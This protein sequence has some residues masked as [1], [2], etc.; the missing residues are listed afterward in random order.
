[1][2]CSFHLKC[3]VC[4]STYLIKH[5]I[6][7]RSTEF[8]FEC[9]K[10]GI[11]LSGNVN[12][13]NENVKV[14]ATFNNLE[15]FKEEKKVEADI[16]YFIQLSGEFYDNKLRIGSSSDWYMPGSFI[17]N[18]GEKIEEF[19]QLSQYIIEYI[20]FL[21]NRCSRVI[22]LIVNNKQNQKYV[23][24]ELNKMDEY[25]QK[26]IDYKMDEKS[27]L[28][29]YCQEK[30]SILF[31]CVCIPFKLLLEKNSKYFQ[32]DNKRNELIKIFRDNKHEIEKMKLAFE[33]VIQELIKSIV[34]KLGIYTKLL[35][36]L[37]PVIASE[38]LMIN[39]IDSIKK[40]KGLNTVDYREL[41]INYA[42]VYEILG[43]FI[44]VMVAID[45]ILNRGDMSSFYD[46]TYDNLEK[47]SRDS[48][49]NRV[50]YLKKISSNNLR[51]MDMSILNN[52]I[53]NSINHYSYEYDSLNQII[54]FKD[55]TKVLDTYL[56]EFANDNY[57]LM[58]L[59]IEA[60]FVLCSLSSKFLS[61]K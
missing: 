58:Y 47:F 2:N 14:S 21:Y 11:M 55:R 19:G 50:S 3:V 26:F 8:Y 18:N 34:S 46:K 24:S 12:I 27:F 49:G 25:S 48:I 23:F 7:Y 4:E 41:L 52:R 61:M 51:Y 60:L 28:K 36:K 42:D 5:Q 37:T 20:P 57:K 45:N 40:Y 39:E 56:I 43:K 16:D 35:P 22:Q 9:P 15:E 6:G 44:P 31:K 38:T 30:N 53:R 13:D 59:L 32:L 29:N 17:Q 10:C 1:M 54:H 33:D